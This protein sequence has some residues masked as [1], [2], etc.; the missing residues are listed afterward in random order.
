MPGQATICPLKML[1]TTLSIQSPSVLRPEQA[2]QRQL[3]LML[4][5]RKTSAALGPQVP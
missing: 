4:L 1:I 3:V 5:L 2:C